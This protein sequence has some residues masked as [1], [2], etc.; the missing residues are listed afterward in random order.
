MGISENKIARCNT[1]KFYTPVGRRGGEC[2]QFGVPV[3][4]TWT[5]CCLAESPFQKAPKISNSDINFTKVAVDKEVVAES[6]AV[7]TGR[8]V[9]SEKHLAVKLSQQI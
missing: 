5:A 6:L 8:F 3:Q 2:S 1:C 4:S 7:P 9:N